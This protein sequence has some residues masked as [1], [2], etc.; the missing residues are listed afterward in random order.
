M[1][2]S[3]QLPEHWEAR[4]TAEGLTYY[5]DHENR[6]STWIHPAIEAQLRHPPRMLPKPPRML[7]K[8]T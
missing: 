1:I 2:G 3:Q 5:I 7:P 8:P 6:R 4:T